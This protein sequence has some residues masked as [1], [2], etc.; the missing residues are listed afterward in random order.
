[1]NFQQSYSSL[2]CHMILSE[3]S[4][5]RWFAVQVTFLII[6]IIILKTLLLIFLWKLWYMF[7]SVMNSPKDLVSIWIEILC[8]NVEVFAVIFDLL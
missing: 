5:I 6:I 4:L 8:N 7:D 3:I 2:Q 1:M